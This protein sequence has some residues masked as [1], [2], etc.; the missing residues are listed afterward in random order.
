M[1]T[2]EL[3]VMTEEDM[4]PAVSNLI[5]TESPTITQLLLRKRM[6]RG[7]AGNGTA[8][9][10]RIR[11]TDGRFYSG[12]DA[13]E[14][15]HTNKHRRF[16][17]LWYNLQE[18]MTIAGTDL[19]ENLGM[20]S[21][22]LIRADSLG[23]F[24][25]TQRETVISVLRA[26]VEAAASAGRFD[27]TRVAHGKISG[28]DAEQRLPETFEDLFDENGEYH[29]VAPTDLP[30]FDE[31]DP[32]GAAATIPGQ[33]STNLWEPRVFEN[34]GVISK[35]AISGPLRRMNA[36]FPGFRLGPLYTDLFD[37]L[38]QE[39]E[40]LI[41]I[42]ISLR[43]LDLHIEGI[44]YNNTFIFADEWAPTDK[45]RVFHVGTRANPG[46]FYPKFWV[47]DEQQLP[48]NVEMMIPFYSQEWMRSQK[49]ADAISS[50]LQAKLTWICENRAAQAEL[51]GLSTS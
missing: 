9:N 16:F 41:R 6:K 4:I 48:S 30:T 26:E 40:D 19:E 36:R 35:A 44:T 25:R 51:R 33:N 13:A 12:W 24:N 23:D 42:P 3:T 20:R 17:A 49:S 29:G 43:N 22:R 34:V 27:I 21:A 45:M 18:D 38:A 46:T 14:R 31:N 11:R 39:F 5:E 1:I 15:T 2:D 32:W 8:I 47:D 28:E 7:A 50:E 37:V 10:V